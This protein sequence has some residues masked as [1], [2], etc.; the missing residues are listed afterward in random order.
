M[1]KRHGPHT[2]KIHIGSA[3]SVTQM[4]R[5][6]GLGILSLPPLLAH[7]VF[8]PR[9]HTK[10]VVAVCVHH[11]EGQ[12]QLLSAALIHWAHLSDAEVR[13]LDPV[14]TP[15]ERLDLDTPAVFSFLI[16]SLVRSSEETQGRR[17]MGEQGPALRFST[18]R[19]LLRTSRWLV[20]VGASGVQRQGV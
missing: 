15:Q 14:S 5:I 12:A 17:A 20:L 19:L 9:V 6:L 2:V 13:H 7:V 10:P 11:P 4:Q 16:S 18:A 8:G 1:F 3:A